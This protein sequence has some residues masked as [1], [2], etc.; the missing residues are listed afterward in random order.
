MAALAA[1]NG[2]FLRAFGFLM[3]LVLMWTAPPK[4]G[5]TIEPVDKDG[6]KLQF[7][8]IAD[9]H[10]T[11]NE[12]GNINNLAKSLQ[13]MR[14]SQVRQDALVLVGDNGGRSGMTNYLTLYSLLSHY[15][16]AK[17]ILAAIGNHDLDGISWLGYGP[18]ERHQFYYRSLT[19]ADTGGKPYYNREINGYTFIVLGSE[20]EIWPMEGEDAPRGY[21][22]QA[23][24]DWLDDSIRAAAAGKPVFIFM[25]QTLN[26]L[27]AWGGIGE[28]SED[29][30]AILERYPN[31]IIFN[32]HMHNPPGMRQVNGVTFVNLPAFVTRD[33]NPEPCRGF[34]VEV[35]DGEV[36]L[37]ARDYLNSEWLTA[38]VYRVAYS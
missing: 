24:L 33:N 28:Q 12:F 15:N 25:H 22:S 13:D 9:T 5:T 21:L 4:Q 29:L 20:Y 27:H 2:L 35:Y 34:Q 10:I 11:I 32:G 36:I 17:N 8:A 30:R 37:R 6:L 38:N 18:Q 16:P 3:S 19:C 31:I 14:A 1:L 23:Q 7:S 26:N